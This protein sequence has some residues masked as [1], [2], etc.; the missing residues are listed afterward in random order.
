MKIV[1][2]NMERKLLKEKEVIYHDP[3][4]E[5]YITNIMVK[6]VDKIVP[7]YTIAQGNMIYAGY[8]PEDNRMIV[9]FT[10]MRKSVEGFELGIYPEPFDY[11][12][13]GVEQKVWDNFLKAKNKINFFEDNI[14]G[15]Y[16][17]HREEVWCV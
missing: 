14:K 7:L 12:Y 8:I 2:K 5:Q 13:D 17:Y 3:T 9:Q 10:A 1:F 11:V 6:P 4:K 15:N 16:F